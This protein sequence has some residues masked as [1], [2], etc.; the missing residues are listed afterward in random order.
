[1][2]ARS[3]LSAAGDFSK[4]SEFEIADGVEPSDSLSLAAA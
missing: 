2:A 1:M 4:R 3:A